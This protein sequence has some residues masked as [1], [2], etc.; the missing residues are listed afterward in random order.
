MS[1]FKG[2]LPFSACVAITGLYFAHKWYREKQA[3]E[4]EAFEDLVEKIIGKQ[5]IFF[6]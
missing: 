3:K 4:Q 6:A 2:F 5:F 1:F